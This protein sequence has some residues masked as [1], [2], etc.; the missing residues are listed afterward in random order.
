AYLSPSPANRDSYTQPAVS[1]KFVWG[2]APVAIAQFESGIDSDAL[3]HLFA[4]EPH[5][6]QNVLLP[7]PGSP[8]QAD[9][10]IVRAQPLL[11]FLNLIDALFD[12]AE[13]EAILCQP[14]EGPTELRGISHRFVLL[15]FNINGSIELLQAGA[16]LLD[17]FSACL[18][19]KS[20]SDDRQIRLSG[21]RRG[22]PGFTAEIDLP[23]QFIDRRVRA[24]DPAVAD[25][26][27]PLYSR[28]GICRDPNG[29]SW[30]LRWFRIQ[31]DIFY[32]EFFPLE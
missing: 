29:R 31:G 12:R 18:G 2:R 3:N 21:F 13:D 1:R 26:R 17:R 10:H 11:V 15:P 28:I 25:F 5:R 4:E 27:G 8:I 20:F 14:I 22:A 19:N 7:Q 30:F 32:L 9:Q 6:R 23:F 24:D 16:R